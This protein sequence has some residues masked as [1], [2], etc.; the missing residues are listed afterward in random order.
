[1]LANICNLLNPARIIVGGELARA[2][3]LVLD[4]IRATLRRTAMP[5]IRGA[6]V[7]PADLGARADAVV[8][9]LTDQ[10]VAALLASPDNQPEEAL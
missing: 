1:M 2:G 10:L 9:R 5:L 4:P 8:L 6:D 3:D 7:V